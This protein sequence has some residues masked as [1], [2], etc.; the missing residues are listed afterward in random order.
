MKARDHRL[1]MIF[2]L[3][4]NYL[5]SYNT[6]TIIIIRD[7]QKAKVNSDIIITFLKVNIDFIKISLFL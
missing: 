4:V 3:L 2:I 7:Y 5:L 1:F 6:N